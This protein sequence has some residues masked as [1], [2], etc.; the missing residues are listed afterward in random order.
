MTS[1]LTYRV[2]LS[3]AL[4]VTATV[5]AVLA[6]NGWLFHRQ[7]LTGLDLLNAAE[8][9]EISA[10]LGDEKIILNPESIEERLRNHTDIDGA[11][12]YF[13][14]QQPE[15]KI[16]FRSSNLGSDELPIRAMTTDAGEVE[17]GHK[18]PVH[19][20]DYYRG[21]MHIQ[22]AAP[23]RTIE[24]LEQSH[25]RTSGVVIVFVAIASLGLGYGFSRYS[26]GPVRAIQRTADRIRA[27]NLSER[28][29]VPKGKGELVELALLLN[30]MFDRIEASFS[31]VRRFTADASHELKTPLALVRL[32]GEKLLQRGRL[33][34]ADEKCVQDLLEESG[35]LQ[36]IIDD[37]LVIAKA[38]SNSLAFEIRAQE[39]RLF[40]EDFAQDAEA[41]AED[42][43]MI[44]SLT[45]NGEGSTNFDARWIRQVLLNIV[46]NSLLASPQG[47]RITL[48][49][50]IIDG[51]WKVLLEDE[52]PGVPHEQLPQLFGRFVRLNPN[53]TNGTG[54]GLAICRSILLAHRGTIVAEN[55]TDRSGLR[56]SFVI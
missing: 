46:S 39:P 11:L 44:F 5:I 32:Q 40:L 53:P 52:G 16:V 41:L 12:Y 43:G 26:L 17:L 50:Q 23:L 21:S 6:L 48:V 56:V 30:Q 2:T 31:E 36:R 37:L 29:P 54:L 55:R 20:S 25:R 27:D 9:A 28:I 42:R 45:M 4:I 13:Q 1:S 49:S 3:F 8:Y 14:V 10:R 7:L 19:L 38:E 24:S 33:E 22:I 35:R 51:R 15:G 18:G 34:S 47:G